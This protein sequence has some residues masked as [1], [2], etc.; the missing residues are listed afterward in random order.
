MIEI[1]ESKILSFQ[2]NEVLKGKKVIKVFPPTH[3]HKLAWFEGDPIL[4]REN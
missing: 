2:A 4:W 1:P 3:T